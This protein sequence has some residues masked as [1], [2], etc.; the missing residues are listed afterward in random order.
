[1]FDLLVQQEE[2]AGPPPAYDLV[3]ADSSHKDCITLEEVVSESCPRCQ[4][5]KTDSELPSYEAA[6]LLKDTRL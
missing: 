2:V 1:M 4:K 5:V 6:V 3:V